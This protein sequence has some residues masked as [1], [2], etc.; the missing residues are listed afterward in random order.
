MRMTR[1]RAGFLLMIRHGAHPAAIDVGASL[2]GRF[3]LANVF[4]RARDIRRAKPTLRAPFIEYDKA[5]E[6]L[7]LLSFLTIGDFGRAHQATENMAFKTPRAAAHAR[8]H[9]V[10]S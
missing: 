7:Y 8:N 4:G 10:I 5:I 1:R 2:F 9:M 3:A 6:L